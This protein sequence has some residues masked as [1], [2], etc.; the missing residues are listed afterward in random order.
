MALL[1][2][3]TLSKYDYFTKV[4]WPKWPFCANMPLINYSLIHSF[5]SNGGK[6]W[7][8]QDHGKSRIMPGKLVKL[9]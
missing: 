8:G 7:Y 1:L 5:E 4:L 9:S 2:F 3:C 6:I